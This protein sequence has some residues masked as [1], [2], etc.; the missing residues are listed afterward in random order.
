MPSLRRFVWFLLAVA[1]TIPPILVARL[2]VTWG[3]DV[4]V[5]DE[6]RLSLMFA[7]NTWVPS[8]NELT[9]QA[10]DSIVMFPKLLWVSMGRAW[11]W[12]LIREMWVTLG[13]LVLS[14]ALIGYA[15]HRT[16]GRGALATTLPLALVSLILFTPA[17]HDNLLWGI[18]LVVYVPLLAL[19][20]LL[21]LVLSP[22]RL[23]TVLALSAVIGTCAILSYAN[24]L[25]VWPLSLP[26]LLW[27][28]RGS[29]RREWPAWL[30]WL[31][32]AGGSIWLYFDALT[33]VNADDP[34]L[35][36]GQVPGIGQLHGAWLAALKAYLSYIGSSLSY[37]DS[38]FSIA[39]KFQRSILSGAALLV[40]GIVAATA[41][42]LW[43][44]RS[45]V[46]DA[47]VLWGTFAA[48]GLASG[49]LIVLGR[50]SY[51]PEYMLSS[52]YVSFSMP[53]VIAV[54]AIVTLALS[55]A[56]VGRGA[57]A[58]V[59]VAAGLVLAVGVGVLAVRGGQDAA[60]VIRDV[61]RLRLHAKSAL[62]F[63]DLASDEQ[64]VALNW[65]GAGI[66]R[67]RAPMLYR[68]GVL[69][70]RRSRTVFHAQDEG[71]LHASG[72][73][74]AVEDLGGGPARVSGWA[75]LTDRNRPADAVLITSQADDRHTPIALAT[76]S[77]VRSEIVRVLGTDDGLW[78]GWAV[79]SP[80]ADGFRAWAF[81]AE[82]NAA[83][84]LSGPCD[85]R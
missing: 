71:R 30:A 40:I 74:E 49:V 37:A 36:H 75:F 19:T 29:H 56:A 66:V 17:Q 27:F 6:W 2:I 8:W 68:V 24:G 83:F 13:A 3:V 64:L 73:I 65:S 7:G 78:T 5:G 50:F 4:P 22:L 35:V 39:D 81:D 61:Y 11:H 63:F 25:L 72:C 32:C 54:V 62:Q 51:G 47:L 45:D 1:V 44:R 20:A 79:V 55:E 28:R 84:P 46:F 31:G 21:A 43:R 18:Q 15:W 9:R 76:P 58:R 82:R 10:N 85:Q 26:L 14:G 60:V 70:D 57:R 59:A 52:R 53:I 41:L 34:G 67:R 33:T 12:N 38:Q 42:L 48:Y 80:P 16:I 69:P 23:R 77:I